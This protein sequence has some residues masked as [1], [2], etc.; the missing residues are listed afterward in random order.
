M[1]P[2]SEF[3]DNIRSTLADAG[4]RERAI[5]Q[6]AY[7]KSDMPYYG[8]TSPELTALLRPFVKQFQPTSRAEWQAIVLELWDDAT[9][10]EERY[11]AI[12]LARAKVAH[13]WYDPDVLPLFRHL[14]VTGAWWDFVDVIAAHLVGEV[15]ARHRE[16]VT[17][18]MREWSVANERVEDL[19]V[20]RTAVLCQLRHKESTDRELLRDV[21]EANLDDGSFWLRKAIGWALREFARTDPGWV[22]A[23]V[24]GWGSSLSG[25]SRREAL[26]HLR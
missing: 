4:N 21:I 19:W 24:D 11:S 23:E 18:V 22:V 16:A 17:P 20:R 6:Q 26:K 1:A 8:I 2:A 13:Q 5:G 10:R 12:A 25:L 9:H 3:V 15:L 14:V 7:M